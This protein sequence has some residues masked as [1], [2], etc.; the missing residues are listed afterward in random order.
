MNIP[1]IN[2]SFNRAGTSF[3]PELS[4]LSQTVFPSFLSVSAHLTFLMPI[5]RPFL[6]VLD[7]FDTVNTVEP[8]S[9]PRIRAS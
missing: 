5:C 3:L 2:A 9:A 4:E 7:R 6:T 1:D 8:R